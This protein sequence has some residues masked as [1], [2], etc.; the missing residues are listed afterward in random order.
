MNIEIGIIFAFAAMLCWGFG[1]FLIQKSTRRFGDWE[2]LFFISV[3]GTAILF[4]F[5]YKDLPALFSSF[6]E[7]ALIFFGAS[8][9]ILISALFEFESLKQGKIAVIEPLW[10]LEVPVAAL[11]AF[12]ILKEA[13]SYL[14]SAMILVLVAGLVLVSLRT[15]RLERKVWLEKAVFIAVFS[16]LIMGAANFLVGLCERET[17]ALVINWFLNVFLMIACLIYLLT[18]KKAR[19]LIK[20]AKEGGWSLWGMCILDNAAWIAFAYAMVFA[21]IGIAV[22]LTEGF[23]IIAVLFGLFVNKENLKT[24]QKIG[25][26][27]AVIAAIV[28]AGSVG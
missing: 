11:F 26:V 18:Q 14:Q 17:N 12:F 16:A 3:L 28:L 27:L 23:I 1:D 4:P 15:Y 20:N 21:P 19:I 24:H 2:T 25:L 7:K 9:A 10:S 13:P 22:A 6:N 5:V 8:I